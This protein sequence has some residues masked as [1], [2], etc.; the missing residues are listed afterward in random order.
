MQTEFELILDLLLSSSVDRIAQFREWSSTNSEDPTIGF[1]IVHSFIAN[2]VDDPSLKRN[3]GSAENPVSMGI[4]D[5]IEHSLLQRFLDVK[6]EGILQFR[7]N[8][9]TDLRIAFAEHIS[10][11][12]GGIQ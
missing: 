2:S 3:I 7:D 5:L 6:K 1:S 11:H 8:V 10:Q 12:T 9:P 4:S